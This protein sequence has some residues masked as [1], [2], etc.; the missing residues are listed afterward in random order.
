M[1][2]STIDILKSVLRAD[3]TLSPAERASLLARM[4]E[5]PEDSKAES[6]A[7]EE[8]RIMRRN[9][10]AR[11]L[12]CSTRTLDKLA[13]AG[14]LPRRKLPGRVRAS[15]FLASDVE[16]LIRSGMRPGAA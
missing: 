16:A 11:R 12:S 14:V 10:A 15:G 8:V 1:L 13:A 4:R 7:K 5:K 2:P 3:P 6:A 9:E